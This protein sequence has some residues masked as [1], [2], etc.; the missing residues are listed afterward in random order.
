MTGANLYAG[1]VA[2]WVVVAGNPVMVV[3]IVFIALALAGI[4][5]GFGT[6]ARR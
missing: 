3:G 2:L 6:G 5:L 1:A 4:V